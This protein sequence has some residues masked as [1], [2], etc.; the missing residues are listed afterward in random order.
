MTPRAITPSAPVHIAGG[1]AA[2]DTDLIIRRRH[3]LARACAAPSGGTLLDFGCGNGSQTALFAG[4][5]DRVVGVDVNREYLAQFRAR[6]AQAALEAPNKPVA[7]GAR[8]QPAG[9]PGGLPPITALYFDGDNIPLRTRSVDYAVSFEVLEHVRDDRAV[10]GELARVVRPDGI[11]VVSVPNRWWIFETHGT[12]LPVLRWNRVPFFSWLPT[13]I[14]D[15][16]ARARI[17]SRRRI[18]TRLRDA[19]FI[20]FASAWITAPMDALSP[21]YLREVLRG[22]LFRGDRAV[23]PILATSIFV[24][25]RRVR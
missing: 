8:D 18:V 10:L 11:L 23:L 2:D 20:P 24:A 4:A 14:H 21:G 17:Y 22:T 1:K 16:F 5:F 19:G 25:S 12:N 6:Y 3:R 7:R 15:R 9:Q 13:P